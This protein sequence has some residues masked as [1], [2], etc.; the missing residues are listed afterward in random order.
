MPTVQV[1]YIVHDIDAA[2]TFYTEQLGFTLVMHPSPP[3]A[4]LTRGD[5]RLVLS[6]P[7]PTAGGGQAMPDGRKQ[8]PGGWNRFAIEVADLAAMVERLRRA[9]A[10]FR[11]EIVT[12]VGGRQILLEDPSG[13]PIELFEPLIPEARLDRPE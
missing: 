1:R 2:I 12:G 10:R 7:N 3:F 8:E 6:A 5:L 13:N 9:G 11:N 4:M